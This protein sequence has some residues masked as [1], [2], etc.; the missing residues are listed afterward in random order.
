MKASPSKILFGFE[1]RNHCDNSLARFTQALADVETE[2]EKERKDSRDTALHATNV[3]R[4][5][6]KMYRDSHCKKPTLYKDG[7]YILIRDDR[8]KIGVSSK[9]KPKYKGPYQ[10]S[11]S[12]GNNRYVV[13]DI[14]GFNITQK[15][16]DTILSSDRIKPWVKAPVKL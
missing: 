5:Y 4:N 16:M 6:N 3:L 9:L 10:V 2:L 13:T 1:Q 12:L 14:P 11:K 7:D 15:P 8:S